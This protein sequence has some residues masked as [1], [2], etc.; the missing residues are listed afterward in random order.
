MTLEEE[1][2][3][4][5]AGR[6][7]RVKGDRK[8]TRKRPGNGSRERGGESQKAKERVR[9]RK[10]K[11]KGEEESKKVENRVAGVRRK[12]RLR[13]ETERRLEG[14]TEKER[15][16]ETRKGDRI[17]KKRRVEGRNCRK[18]P[19]ARGGGR[20]VPGSGSRSQ[21]APLGFIWLLSSLVGPIMQ[22]FRPCI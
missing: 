14:V 10:E 21:R 12:R 16:R 4:V 1:G 17:E 19:K 7:R 3:K 6:D 9:R 22:A 2:R 11:L 13:Q 8:E 15:S 5:M 20:A 18:T